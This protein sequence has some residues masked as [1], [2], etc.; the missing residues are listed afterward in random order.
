MKLF[1]GV[2]I[3]EYGVDKQEGTKTGDGNKV[4]VSRKEIIKKYPFLKQVES[5]IPKGTK[6]Y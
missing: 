6:R 4:Y 2:F 1:P 5:K 3:S